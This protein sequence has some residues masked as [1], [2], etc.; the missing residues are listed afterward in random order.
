MTRSVR[1]A[2]LLLSG[3]LLAAGCASVPRD[4]AARAEFKA[5][6]DPVEP[7][8]RRI[9][10][11]N[12]FFDRILIKPLA[13]GYVRIVPKAGRTAIRHFLDN[14]DEP[15][16]LANTFLQGR[17]KAAATAGGRFLDN[18]LFG[19]A[20]LA[21]VATGDRL[22]KQFGDFG[23]TLWSWGLPEGPYLVVPL[24]GPTNPRDGIGSGVDIYIDP[25]RYV[26]R[27][28]DYATDFSI[29]RAVADGIDKRADSLDA[30]DEIQRESIDYY[31][32]F[33]SYFRQHRTSEVKNGWPAAAQPQAPAGFYEDP[34][35]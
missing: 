28:N 29:G 5:N 34:G 7:L 13:K 33:R 30:L 20:G 19:F 1:C 18:T 23:Q 11:F 2:A 31:A 14:L 15:I 16:V 17:P 3:T 10:A 27:S 25:F 21:D 4:P 24:F 35:R 8:N 26:A 9:F 32:S 6:N 22:H 12:L